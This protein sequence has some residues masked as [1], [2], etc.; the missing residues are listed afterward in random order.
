MPAAAVDDYIDNED[1]SASDKYTHNIQKQRVGFLGAGNMSCALIQGLISDSNCTTAD[2]ISASIR[3]TDRRDLLEKLGITSIYGDALEGG[4]KQVA[5]DSDIIFLGVKPQV[6]SPVM[7]ALAPH[8]SPSR[9]LVISI[10]AGVPLSKLE[11]ALGKNVRVVRCMPNTPLLVGAG[12][13]AYALGKHATRD[14]AAL[15]HMM[16]SGAGIA[17]E[18]DEKCMDAVTGLSGSGPAYIFMAIDAMA[19]GGV[20][21]GLPR[22]V[23]RQLAAQTVLGA[24]KMVLETGSHP[25]EL[26]D[27]VASPGGTTIA[28]IHELEKAGLRASLIN[29]VTV[30][31]AR[32]KQ[33][34][35]DD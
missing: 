24:A 21:A 11:A 19:D 20:K 35:D 8:L 15:V 31:A 29:A 14:D 13:S 7:E 10:A 23:A 32:S 2:K 3:S 25:G 33:L 17:L 34:A 12:A 22:D 28:G 16:L 9:H 27:A 5:E 26:K 4:A 30:A 1:E 18:V 6:M